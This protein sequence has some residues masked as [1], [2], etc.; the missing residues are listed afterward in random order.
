MELIKYLIRAMADP[1]Y[2]LSEDET[3]TLSSIMEARVQGRFE[4]ALGRGMFPIPLLPG[5]L[6]LFL[7][8]HHLVADAGQRTFV[9]YCTGSFSP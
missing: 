2:P 6:V 8:A 3:A 4:Y 9:S 5:T 1:G 7:Y